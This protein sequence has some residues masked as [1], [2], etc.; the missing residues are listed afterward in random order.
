[1]CHSRHLEVI[2]V[3]DYEAYKIDVSKKRGIEIRFTKE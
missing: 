2:P 3:E 1:V